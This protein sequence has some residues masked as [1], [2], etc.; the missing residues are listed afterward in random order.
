V[1]DAVPRC[2]TVS[3]ALGEPLIGTASIV[4]NWIL[5]EQPGPWGYDAVAQ[6]RLPTEVGRELRARS[7]RL[8]IR[9]ILIRRPGRSTPEGSRCYFGHTSADRQ[10]LQRTHL[11]GGP[12]DLLDM[13]WTPLGRGRRLPEIPSEPEALH[14]VCTNGARD[15]C[16]AERGREV[17]RVLEATLGERVWECSHI[18]GDRFA[19]NLVCFPHGVYFGRVSPHRAVEVALAYEAGTLDLEHYRGRSCFDFVTQ[20]AE[21]YVRLSLGVT[22][23]GD[24]RLVARTEFTGRLEAEFEVPTGRIRVVVAEIHGERPQPLT[25]QDTAPSHPPRYELMEVSSIF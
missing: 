2:S 25:C 18:G 6:S 5:L 17:A 10:S 4:R 21:A 1:R 15:R 24:V 13:D 11:P 19:A 22:G 16:C 23:L 3:R 12:A 8:G 14:V 20:A 7:R 9:L